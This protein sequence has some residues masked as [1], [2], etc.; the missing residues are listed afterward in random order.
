MDS[1]SLGGEISCK[2]K[3]FFIKVKEWSYF[4]MFSRN[5]FIQSFESLDFFSGGLV[6][7]VVGIESI[8]KFPA[9]MILVPFS[10]CSVDSFQELGMLDF[11]FVSINRAGR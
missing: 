4:L 8:E 10:L 6:I 3:K 7:G 5:M 1:R 2:W 11:M 9:G